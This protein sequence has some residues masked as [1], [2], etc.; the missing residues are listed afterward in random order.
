M[1]QDKK[2]K[3]DQEGPDGSADGS[4]EDLN[5]DNESQGDDD[6]I[7]KKIAAEAALLPSAS[8]EGEDDD[9]WAVDVSEDAVAARMKELAVEGAVAKLM[10]D[11]DDNDLVGKVLSLFYIKR[12][13][14]FEKKR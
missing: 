8:K 12:N 14:S 7:T 10:D 1:F 4:A 11:D 5:E 6:M 3:K 13:N 9:D 2:S